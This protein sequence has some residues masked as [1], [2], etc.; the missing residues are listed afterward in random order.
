[1]GQH[2]AMYN[3]PW[4]ASTMVVSKIAEGTKTLS[5][6]LANAKQVAPLNNGAFLAP[7]ATSLKNNMDDQYAFTLY[8]LSTDTLPG[9]GTSVASI[10]TALKAVTPLGKAVLTGHAGLNG[11]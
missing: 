3:I 8:A 4:N 6:D 5:G 9:A 2:W 7:C 10:V 1:M 11:K